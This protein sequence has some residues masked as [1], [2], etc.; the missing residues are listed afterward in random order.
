MDST[1]PSRAEPQG[2]CEWTTRKGQ[3]QDA[4]VSCTIPK[5][6]LPESLKRPL[7]GAGCP[8]PPSSPDLQH[9]VHRR[10]LR[11]KCRARPRPRGHCPSLPPATRPCKG[12]L[13]ASSCLRTWPLHGHLGVQGHSALPLNGEAGHPRLCHLDAVQAAPASSQTPAA[14]PTPEGTRPSRVAPASPGVDAASADDRRWFAKWPAGV[15]DTGKDSVAPG[16]GLQ[17][18]GCGR[19]EEVGSAELR[20]FSTTRSWSSQLSLEV[21]EPALGSPSGRPLL[22]S[23]L[24]RYSRSFP[25]S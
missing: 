23:Y 15:G 19:G 8:R 25:C 6:H 10:A 9:G 2:A 22:W 11:R 4:L 13:L 18:V 21:T 17:N 7:R 1:P 3:G 14:P 5:A 12:R 20:P 16:K 24:L